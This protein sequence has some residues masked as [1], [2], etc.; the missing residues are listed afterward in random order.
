MT[1]ESFEGLHQTLKGVGVLLSDNWVEKEALK[2]ILKEHGI[3]FRERLTELLGRPDLREQAQKL[4]EP[5]MEQLAKDVK[6][7]W[8]E[9]EASKFIPPSDAES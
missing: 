7:A 4:F 8:I 1:R 5:N 9:M 3:E 2:I 6:A